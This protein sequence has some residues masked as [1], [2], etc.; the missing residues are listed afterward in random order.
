MNIVVLLKQVHDPNMSRAAMRI[1]EDHKT[2]VLPAAS[3]AILNGFDANAM[4]ES[5]R[6]RDKCGGTVTAISVGPE[7]TKEILRRAIAMGADKALHIVGASG[8][9]SDSDTVAALLAAAIR[10]LG[11]TD[12]VLSGR[13]ASDTDA[14]VVPLRVAVHLG[15]SVVTPVRSLNVVEGGELIA[16]RIAEGRTRRVRI[17]GSAVIG[18]SNEINKPRSPSLKG[19]VASKRATIPSV[20]AQD[21]GV[22]PA[23]PTL[24]LRRLFKPEAPTALSELIPG[25]SAEEAGR[26]LA[27]RLRQDGL[28]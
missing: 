25:A 7:S 12:F 27:D 9:D 19:V 16:D 20:T 10:S 28:I 6:L 22:A 1:A 24:L 5:L 8:L 2:L 14:G 17:A 15:F 26:A 3:A 23:E 21:L 13:S 4:E 11:P 18:V